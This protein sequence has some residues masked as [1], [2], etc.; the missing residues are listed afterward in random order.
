M[1]GFETIALDVDGDVA[2]LALKRPERRNAIDMTMRAE[3]REAVDRLVRDAAI[4][5]CVLTGSGGSFCAGGDITSMRDRKPGIEDARERMRQTGETVLA[6]LSLE[7]PLIAAVDG[8]AYGAGFGLAAAA[9]FVVATPQARFCASFARIGLVPDFA[10]HHSLPRR[11][12][13]GR[14]RELILSAR[15][16]DAEEALALGIAS[17]IVEQDRLI[18]TATAMAKSFVEASATAFALSKNLLNQSFGL[19]LRQTVE[20]ESV[21]QAACLETAYHKEAAQRFLDGKPPRF[22]WQADP[23]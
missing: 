20:A 1:A 18:V 8:P 3:L 22:R 13:M 5:A 21:A 17:R 12:G 11:V 7:K 23:A 2:T 6:L 15:E 10:L 9:D 19:D 16:V 14:A 4:R